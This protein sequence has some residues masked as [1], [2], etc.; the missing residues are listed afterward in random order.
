MSP[1]GAHQRIGHQWRRVLVVLNQKDARAYTGYAR[2]PAAPLKCLTC[3]FQ[4]ASSETS[5]RAPAGFGGGRPAVRLGSSAGRE[6]YRWRARTA[7][8]L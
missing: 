4:R 5:S 3:I 8:R 2:L 7:A 6:A 1:D